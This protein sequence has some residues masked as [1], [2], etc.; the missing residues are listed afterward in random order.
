MSDADM[1]I[2]SARR[3]G[4]LIFA[5]I[6]L[7]VLSAGYGYFHS[8]TGRIRM[9]KFADLS[10]IAS[11][12]SSQIKQWRK[13]RLGDA[14]RSAT[15]PFFQQA[16]EVWLGDRENPELRVLWKKR[17]KREQIANEYDDVLLLDLD[18]RL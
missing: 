5:V 12:K 13:E 14:T 2:R 1:G 7:V 9:E 4:W 8:E 16:L 3:N 15:S 10:A 6:T 17:L 18:G 11:L